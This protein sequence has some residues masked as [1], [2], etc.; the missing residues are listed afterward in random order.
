VTGA[1]WSGEWVAARLGVG[2][3]TVDAP[4]GVGVADLAGLAVRRNPKRAQ[5]L[6]SRVLAKHV[7]TDPRLVR[8]AGLLLGQLVAAQPAVSAAAAQALA[9]A[10]TGDRMAARTL[11]DLTATPS[12][13]LGATVLGYAETATGLGQAVADA[14][15]APY[16][17]STRRPVPGIATYGGFAEHHSHATDHLLLPADPAFLAGSGPLVLVDDE[18]STGATAL[19]TIAELHSRVGRERYVVAVL[20][21]VRPP[22]ERAAFDKRVAELGVRVDVVALARGVLNV[23]PGIAAEHHALLAGHL[24]APTVDRSTASLGRLEVRWPDG[25]PSTARHGLTPADRARLAG[26]L[27]AIAARLADMVDGPRVLVLGTEE[28]MDAPTRLAEALADQLDSAA[29]S[30]SGSAAPI[31]VDFSSTT[32]S[33]VLPVDEPGYAIR[34]ALVFPAHDD[35]ADGPGERYAYNVV[36]AAGAG[37]G[38]DDVLVVTD[39]VGVTASLAGNGGLLDEVRGAAHRVH[40]VV[41]P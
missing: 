39:A 4:V 10:L 9:A 26:A 27:P 37:P 2:V 11:R 19:N 25:L 38:Y 15:E 21:D 32:R 8:G 29:G 1:I 20:T 31:T 17:H 35:P 16:L 5:L 28:L 22:E 34:T 30:G 6:V 7:P 23:P 40:L 41:L 13:L 18:L 24:P 36:P 33:P 12:P 14:L 3:V